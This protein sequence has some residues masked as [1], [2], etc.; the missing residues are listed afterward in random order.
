LDDC[1][2]FSG[3]ITIVK[4]GG[5]IDYRRAVLFKKSM[6]VEPL[7]S[8]EAYTSRVEK[9]AEFTLTSTHSTGVM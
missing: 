7:F 4:T 3:K 9:M 1:N 6:G 8:H 5:Y 2:S